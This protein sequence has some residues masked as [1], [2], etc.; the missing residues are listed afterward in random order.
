MH[1]LFSIFSIQTS[2]SKEQLRDQLIQNPH[3]YGQT[4]PIYGE[5]SMDWKNVQTDRAQ[6]K[7]NGFYLFRW[8]QGKARFDSNQSGTAI[9]ITLFP[10]SLLLAFFVFA[11]GLITFSILNTTLPLH[12]SSEFMPSLLINLFALV[13]FFVFGLFLLTRIGKGIKKEITRKL[14]RQP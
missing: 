12:G 6:L 2:Q 10:D 7:M 9:K 1:N 3:I 4:Y 13:L 8:Y 5:I 14:R 11:V